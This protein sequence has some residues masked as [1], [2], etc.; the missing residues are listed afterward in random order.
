MR[1]GLLAAG[2]I[3]GALVLLAIP[4]AADHAPSSASYVAGTQSF[5]TNLVQRCDPVDLG[6]AGPTGLTGAC[7]LTLP[8]WPRFRIEVRGVQGNPVTYDFGGVDD[9]GSCGF[10]RARGDAVVELPW[11]CTVRHAYV[12]PDTGAVAGTIRLAAVAPDEPLTPPLPPWPRARPPQSDGEV[13]TGLL[14]IG[15]R[16]DAYA[17]GFCPVSIPFIVIE[18]PVCLPGAAISPF[19]Q[20]SGWVG[21]SGTG[22]AGGLVGVSGTGFGAGGVGVSGTGPARG[23]AAVSGTGDAYGDVVAVSAAGAS[24]GGFTASLLGRA[25]GNFLADPCVAAGLCGD[26]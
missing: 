12:L 6:P 2:L 5:A 20:A 22:D 7:R 17:R 8:S 19:H 23:W 9:D 25:H 18:I 1:A 13:S 10:G 3:V 24:H 16:Q 11:Y 4:A 21:V 15:L 26:S 14:S